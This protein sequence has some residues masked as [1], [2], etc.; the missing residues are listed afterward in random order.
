MTVATEQKRNGVY[1]TPENVV[2]TLV[3]WAIRKESDRLLD[4]S[5]GDGRFLAAHQNSFGVEPDC[6]GVVSA[7]QRAP[8]AGSGLI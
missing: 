1:Y 8:K 4:P 3:R 5:C 2:Q 6:A 7:T